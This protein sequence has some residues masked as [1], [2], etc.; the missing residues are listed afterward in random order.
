MGVGVLVLV[1]RRF[2]ALNLVKEID[3]SSLQNGKRSQTCFSGICSR[4]HQIHRLFNN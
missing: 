1:G 2:L 3:S 4:G